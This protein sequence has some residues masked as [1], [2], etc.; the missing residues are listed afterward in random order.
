MLTNLTKRT[1]SA[2]AFG[3]PR[4]VEVT[5]ISYNKLVHDKDAALE[6]IDRAYSDNGLGTLAISEVPE[7]A[8]KRRKTLI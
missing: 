3:L 8:E 6:A 1:I 7:Y 5:K 4:G 2:S